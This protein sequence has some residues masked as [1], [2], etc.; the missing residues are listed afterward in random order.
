[1]HEPPVQSD[2]C[3]L[4]GN[5]RLESNPERH[6]NAPLA[7]ATGNRMCER[8]C[9]SSW[10]GALTTATLEGQLGWHVSHKTVTTVQKFPNLLNLRKT[11]S[12]G[13]FFV[14]RARDYDEAEWISRFHLVCHPIIQ[15]FG[16]VLTRSPWFVTYPPQGISFFI[17][18]MICTKSVVRDNLSS[19]N[20]HTHKQWLCFISLQ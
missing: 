1:M 3:A 18:L 17:F 12:P 11:T 9:E 19:L 15:S 10:S 16:V 7:A 4:S 8:Y 20:K 6:A 2:R 14:Y 13:G 5:Y